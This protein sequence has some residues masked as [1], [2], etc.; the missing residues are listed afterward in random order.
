MFD[1]AKDVVFSSC[2]DQ[3]VVMIEGL[4]GRL[5]YKNVNASLNCIERNVVMSIY[6]G[7]RASQEIMFQDLAH[8][9]E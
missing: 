7:S 3:S 8:C 1:E 6:T 2:C 9:R 5:G 4:N